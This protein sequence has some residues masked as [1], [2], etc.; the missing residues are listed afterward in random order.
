MATLEGINI[1]KVHKQHSSLVVIV[2][3]A[4]R[5]ALSITAG[6]YVIFCSHP[7]TNIVEF[8][9]FVS[10]DRKNGRDSRDSDRKD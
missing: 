1:Q 5:K 3:K 9:K 7:G 8:S 2:P 4:V 6:S 10:G